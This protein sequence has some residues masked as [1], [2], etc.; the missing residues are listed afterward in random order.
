MLKVTKSF[1]SEV[2]RELLRILRSMPSRNL[3]IILRIFSEISFWKSPKLDSLMH[4]LVHIRGW[5]HCVGIQ[6]CRRVRSGT[7]SRLLSCDFRGKWRLV[8]YSPVITASFGS[9][10]DRNRTNRII[11]RC[12]RLDCSLWIRSCLNRGSFHN[13]FCG[14]IRGRIKMRRMQIATNSKLII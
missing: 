3:I 14:Y 7:F 12:G 8:Q 2:R 1:A 9:L 6:V 11:K 13:T 5:D 4:L 10:C